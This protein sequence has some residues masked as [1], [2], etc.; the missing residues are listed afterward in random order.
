[1]NG[2]QNTKHIQDKFLLGYSCENNPCN[3]L[4]VIEQIRICCIEELKN[5]FYFR[6]P[7]QLVVSGVQYCLLETLRCS[8]DECIFDLL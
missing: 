4:K 7:F 5:V 2:V 1:V 3:N 6:D 8:W